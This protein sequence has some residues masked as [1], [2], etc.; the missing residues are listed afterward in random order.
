VLTMQPRVTDN[1]TES[2]LCPLSLLRRGNFS[3][4]LATCALIQP[5]HASAPDIACACP[6]MCTRASI[7]LCAWGGC[8]C[9]RGCA[10]T[11]GSV[12]ACVHTCLYRISHCSASQAID[13]IGNGLSSSGTECQG[14][15]RA[16]PAVVPAM[17]L[18]SAGPQGSG[19]RV[20]RSP[21][22]YAPA[23]CHA[24][25]SGTQWRVH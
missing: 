2:D 8:G 11:H 13:K 22:W 9:V 3:V 4:P 10:R 7:L 1:A 25:Q 23:Q 19:A 6:R 12:R 5:C 16:G 20:L 17:R 14:S 21:L 15:A 18:C 24:G